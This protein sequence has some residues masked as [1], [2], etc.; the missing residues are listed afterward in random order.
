MKKRYWHIEGYDSSTKIYDRKV[1]FGYFS[2]NQIQNLLKALSA[3]A[4]DLSLDEIVGAYA[5]K[6]TKIAIEL[7]SVQ[8]NGP[9]PV[10]R[11]GSNPHFIARLIVDEL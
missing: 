9:Y 3:K 4:G 6:K 2:E 11:C 7:L 8:K 5:K 10:Y 1:R